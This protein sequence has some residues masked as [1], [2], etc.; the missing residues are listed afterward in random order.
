MA[1][2]EADINYVD[3]PENAYLNFSMTDF[4]PNS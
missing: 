2:R 4:K 1:L 3:A